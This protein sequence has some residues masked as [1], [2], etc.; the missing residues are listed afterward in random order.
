M[1][2]QTHSPVDVT[3]HGAV[4][5][6]NEK[7]EVVILPEKGCDVFELRERR[8]GIDVLAKTRLSLADVQTHRFWR[9]SSEAWLSQY[10]GGWQLILPNGGAA[11]VVGGVEWGFHGEAC[12]LRWTVEEL[13]SATLRASLKLTNVPL[14]VNR[15]FELRG[16]TLKLVERI[17]NESSEGLSFMWSHHPAFG[18]PFIDSTCLISVDAAEVVADDL[19]PGTTMAPGSVH[20]WPRVTAANG[21]SK[22]LDEVPGRGSGE[23]CLAY[24]SDFQTGFFAITNPGLELGVAM[25]WPLEI[26]PH[27]WYWIEAGASK[28]FPWF[29]DHYTVAVEPA[30]SVPAQGMGVLEEK[31]GSPFYLD[32]KESIEAEFEMT[33]FND[34]RRVT[35]VTPGGGIEFESN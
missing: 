28:G 13:S 34:H 30:T 10:V 16:N 19:S 33:I 24:L 1:S 8:S 29:G 22:R 11:A 25:R 26:F 23:A 27:A 32:A 4:T 12:T 17:R 5:L 6:A 31:G 35:R 18:G 20:Q 21:E 14:S 3:P 2:T 15:S 7:I 9:S